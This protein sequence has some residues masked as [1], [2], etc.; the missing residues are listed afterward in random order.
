LIKR[1]LPPW[2]FVIAVILVLQTVSATM[3]RLVPV[4]GPAFTAEFGWDESWVGYLSAASIV[5]ALFA[6]TVGIGIMR[7]MGGVRAFQVSLLIGAAALLLYLIP[8]IG[9]ALIASACVGLANGTANPAGSEVLTR[10]TPPA[11]RNLVF[12]IKQAGVP[13]GG[14]LGGLIIPPL[15]EAMG[16]RLAAAVIAAACIAVTLLTWPFRSRIDL[17]YEQRQQFRLDSFR[18]TDILVPLR[19]LSHGNRLWRASWVGALLAVPQAAWVTFVVTYLVVVLGQSLST[20]GLVFAVM[21][22]TSMLGRVTLGWI[23]DHVMSSTMTLAIASLGSAVSTILLGFSTTAW[24]LWS[25]VV[26]SAF[27]GIA[28]SGWNGVQIAEVARR[29]APE[30]IGET[31]AGSVILIFM[32]NMLTPVAFAAFVA[33]TG[34]YDLAFMVCGA[35]GLICLPLLYG[36]GPQSELN[37]EPHER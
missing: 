16:W 37:S 5:G 1:A 27:A 32:T 8:S 24:P 13:L 10:L 23:A 28:V 7:R 15:I 18:L 26:L 12:S 17:S 2:F 33:L 30:L 25:F 9:L 36:M 14:V 20:A 6:L 19:S 21:Q 3:G 22:T 11:H 31:T 29:S 35:F 34:R 4:A